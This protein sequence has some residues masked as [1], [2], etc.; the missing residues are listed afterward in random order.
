MDRKTDEIKPPN[1]PRKG[2]SPENE[3]ASPLELAVRDTYRF[4]AGAK[5]H[6]EL[7]DVE[8]A[9]RINPR[10]AAEIYA[11]AMA[12][13]GRRLRRKQDSPETLQ[14]V[15]RELWRHTLPSG[16]NKVYFRFLPGSGR[17]F[18]WGAFS[19]IGLPKNISA[20]RKKGGR[21]F[22]AIDYLDTFDG[23]PAPD[24]I[25]GK[26]DQWTLFTE[27]AFY[28]LMERVPEASVS[29][30]PDA[31]K[32]LPKLMLES[33]GKALIEDN[34]GRS[35][36]ALKTPYGFLYFAGYLRIREGTVFR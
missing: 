30:L 4:L 27:H 19:L 34:E 23:Q 2:L 8:Y 26:L 21:L 22:L 13:Q 31:L 29:E 7:A 33:D 9:K 32:L 18:R 25:V 20:H 15:K 28:R 6:A 35:F 11:D 1:P 14:A 3:V 5:G 24:T 16:K 36:L 10:F 12:Q 17:S